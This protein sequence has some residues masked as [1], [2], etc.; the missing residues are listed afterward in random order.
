MQSVSGARLIVLFCKEVEEIASLKLRFRLC[1]ENQKHLLHM[2]KLK[3]Y[4]SAVDY[5]EF[6]KV[7]EAL[8]IIFMRNI[9]I[10][11]ER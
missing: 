9:G 3:R 7:N 8:D 2:L 4:R 1:N 10:H 6:Y 5:D 11:R